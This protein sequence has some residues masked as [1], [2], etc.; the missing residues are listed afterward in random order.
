MTS[1]RDIGKDFDSVEDVVRALLA[2]ID[3]EDFLIGLTPDTESRLR[4][5]AENPSSDF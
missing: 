2:G 3:N 1:D 5:F 4:S